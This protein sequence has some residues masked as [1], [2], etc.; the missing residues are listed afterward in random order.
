VSLT[1]GSR[2]GPYE[3]SAQIGAGGMGEVY[4]ATDINLKRQVALKVLPEAVAA[5]GDRL[6]RFQREAEVL[7]SLNHPNIAIIHGLEKSEGITALVMELVEG[8][9]LAD[10]FVDGPIQI[11]EALGIAK[12]IAEALEAAHEQGVVHRDLKPANVKVRPDG[13]VKVLDFG[14]AKAMG[15]PEGGHSAGDRSVR[16]Q[17]ELSMSP[18]ITTPA[19]TQVGMIMGTAAYMSPEQ[20][21]GRAV[22]KRSDIWA[23]G[24]VLFEMLTGTRTFDGD[25][26]SE[27]LAS[28]LAREPDWNRLPSDVPAVVAIYLRRCLQKN[29]KARIADV[30]DLRL[31]LTG[32][33]DVAVPTRDTSTPREPTRPLWRR[34][35]PLVTT[36]LVVAVAAASAAWFRRPADPRPVMRSIHLLP[37]GRTFRDL[38]AQVVAIA[39]DGRYFIYSGTG[40]LYVR[41]MDALEDRLIPGTTESGSRD[42]IVSPDGQSVAVFQRSLAGG[43]LIRMPI[44]G[45]A[46]VKLTDLSVAFGG[47]WG[48]DGRILYT[49]TGGIWEVSENGGTPRRVIA[50]KSDELAFRPQRLPGRD[51]ILFTVTRT[52]GGS[53]WDMADIVV[54]SVGTGERRV[55]RRGGSDGRYLPTGH[56]VYAYQDVLYG[57]VFDLD[58]LE[59]TGEI[60]PVVQGV[61]RVEAPGGNTGAA[62]FGVSTNGTLVYVPGTSSAPA[63][64]T[65]LAWVAA[66]GTR[67]ALNLSPGG[68][69]HPRFSP[70]GKWLAVERQSGATVDI[71]IYETSGATELRRLTNGGNNRFPVWSRDGEYV[72]FQSDRDGNPGIFQQKFDGTGSAERLTAADGKRS[73][74]PE[75]W[76]PTKDLLA[77]TVLDGAVLD[78]AQAELW[79][80]SQSDRKTTRFGTL[81]SASLF[82]AVFSPDGRWLAYSQRNLAAGINNV[83]TYVHSVASPEVRF[84]V[85]RDEDT[86]HHPL[87]SPNG[88]QLIYFPGGG[89]AVAVDVRTAPSFGFGRPTALPGD[90]LPINV[91]PGSL[92]NHDVH[93][94]GRFVTVADIEPPNGD[95]RNRN[96]IVIVQN[97]FEELKRMVPQ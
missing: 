31:A 70:D 61:R 91:S 75:D 84:Q 1:P 93:P 43:A 68:Y 35:L 46:K 87:W 9:T 23:F 81:Q 42:V 48:E 51:W 34:A 85:G 72:A 13:T 82:D 50:L 59:V 10:R 96:A 88:R 95:A 97:W 55:L 2:L 66:D 7:A 21:R 76:S 52:L 27:T 60:A 94:D 37:E 4:R 30:Q 44:A 47:T 62:F 12:Q 57:A 49:Q 67:T 22:D 45:G 64:S 83:L 29:P 14:L 26:V 53:R 78:G 90:G 71:W 8:P 74:I 24:C 28:V 73:H 32:A 41:S 58:R 5:D 39:P 36:V 86:V 40:G 19:M 69:A 6:A 92:L 77:F 63:G 3:I 17:P 89:A 11:E 65:G 79:M 15:P 16:L 20:A 38:G 25:D 18:T 33:F 54:E 80:W 56:L